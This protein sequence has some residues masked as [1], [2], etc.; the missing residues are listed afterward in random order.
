MNFS[1][2]ESNKFYVEY[3][4]CSRPVGSLREESEI[5]AREIYE[6]NNKILLCLSSGLDSQIALHSFISQGIPIECAFLRLDGFNEREY[7]N[8]KILEKKYGLKVHIVNLNPNKEKEEL[9]EIGKQL[10][11]QVIHSLHYKFVEQLPKEHDIVQVLHDPWI[12]TYRKNKKHYIFH[13]PS[14]PEI[15]RYR[16][17]AAVPRSGNIQMFGDSSELFLSLISDPI[18]DYFL[19]SWEYFDGNGLLQYNNKIADELRYDY[20]IK[21]MIYA[22]HWS[23]ELTYFAKFSGY[24]NVDW[25]FTDSR[26]LDNKHL[27]FIERGEL[28]NFLKYG[29]AK[30]RWTEIDIN[31]ILQ[32]K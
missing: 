27:C 10:D 16:A 21:P 18:F 26:R 1:F 3:F 20:Y 32:D 2:D 25:M 30:K 29:S 17:I 23:T 5:R 28:I 11:V 31:L 9:I 13:E 14:D 22:K 8:L 19:D 6:K 4:P 12:T 15:A 7:E 24:E